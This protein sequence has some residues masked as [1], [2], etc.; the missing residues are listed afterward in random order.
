MSYVI[1]WFRK[2]LRLK[3]NKALYE[4]CQSGRPVMCVYIHD[5]SDPYSAAEA[6]NAWLHHS[7]SSLKASLESKSIRLLIKKGNPKEVFEEILQQGRPDA[8]YCNERYD[9]HS[10]KVDATVKYICEERKIRFHTCH[11]NMFSD[12][13][14][15]VDK[16]GKY[17]MD[18]KDYW[19][20]INKITAP[21]ALYPAPSKI[22][23]FSYTTHG[24]EIADLNLLTSFH[25]KEAMK[26]HWKAGEA[27]AAACLKTFLKS[28]IQKYSKEKS[29]PSAECSSKLS[30]HLNFGE[31]SPFQV[32]DECNRLIERS[33]SKTIGDEVE[34]FIKDM[35]MG[36]FCQYSLYHTAEINHLLK[37][38]VSQSFPWVENQGLFSA[39]KEGRT[40]Y[41]LIDAA[42]R[43][44]Q[45]M[46]FMHST[47]ESAAAIFLTQDL[48]IHAEE[49]IRW[50]YKNLFGLDLGINIYNWYAAAGLLQNNFSPLKNFNPT[51]LSARLDKEGK[52]IKTW[53]PELKKLP[54]KYI[55]APS[56][57]PAAVLKKAGIELGKN[58]PM[59]VVDH[60]KV[61]KETLAMLKARASAKVHAI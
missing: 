4:A 29:I 27:A 47:G 24:V 28:K 16:K 35:A 51:L 44:L 8:I 6:H 13:N 56:K 45:A 37:T 3:D 5:Q 15:I 57:A 61:A 50:Y 31:I 49:G 39:W 30:P 26:N 59:P 21:R 9:N 41:P 11:S 34:E 55:H 38:E 60:T 14:A 58:Y 25:A 42:M 23:P 40:G 53:V 32:L 17:L 33:S 18:F 22:K 7:L 12:P 20:Q 19:S 1:H 10:R 54:A 36:Q 52:Y 2:D 48:R 43:Q 46:G